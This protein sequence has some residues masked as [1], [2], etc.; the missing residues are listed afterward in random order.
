MGNVIEVR[1]VKIGEGVPKIIVP[2]VGVTKEEILAAAASFKE[3]RLDLVEWRVDWFEGVF[4]FAKVEDVLKDL[5]AALGNTPIL[6]TFR[7][8]KEGGEKPIEAADYAKLNISAAKTGLVDLIDVEAFTGDEIVKEIIEGAHAA[9]VKVVA[10]NHDFGKTPDKD[11]IVGRLRK[12]QD[13]GADIPKIA[14]MPKSKKD[15]LVLLSATEEMATDYADRPIITM[16]MAGTGVISRLAGE[17]FGSAL[18][19]GA[20]AKASAPGQMGVEDLKQVLTLLH[21]AL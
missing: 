19:F 9:G 17:V 21:G 15:V 1:G 7:T 18:T 13:L 6:F 8:S 16:S 14:V 2:I 12:M 5:R 20:A 11:D 3:V 10:S 4:D